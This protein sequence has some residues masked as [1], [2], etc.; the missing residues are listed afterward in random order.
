[1]T[2]T[3]NLGQGEGWAIKVIGKNV[4]VTGGRERG[5]LYGVYHLLEDVLGVRWWNMWEEYVPSMTD[6]VI[7]ADYSDSGEPVFTYRDVFFGETG[8]SWVR[9][10]PGVTPPEAD[11]VE[12]WH[13]KRLQFVAVISLMSILTGSLVPRRVMLLF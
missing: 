7:P 3:D 9:A 1:M 12:D 4:V 11:T 6:A 10:M 2:Y 5:V 13:S 8:D